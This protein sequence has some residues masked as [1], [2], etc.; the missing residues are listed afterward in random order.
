MENNEFLIREAFNSISSNYR[1]ENDNYFTFLLRS[2]TRNLVSKYTS[3]YKGQ[4]RCLEI[5]SGT[6]ED[7]LWFLENNWEILS[8]DIS[9]KMCD[10]ISSIV[11]KR[12]NRIPSTLEISIFLHF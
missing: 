4:K 3:S 1:Y 2:Q 8:T 5:G 9:P 10:E 7:T 11:K 6:G 12:Y